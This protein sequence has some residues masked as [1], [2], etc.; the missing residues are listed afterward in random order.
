MDVGSPGDVRAW[1]CGLASRAAAKS[2]ADV[3]VVQMAAVYINDVGAKA[4]YPP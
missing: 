1:S 3:V 4:P 2:C